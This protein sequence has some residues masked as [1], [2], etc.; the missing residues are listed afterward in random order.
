[1][2]VWVSTK[3]RPE[4]AG[5]GPALECE[6]VRVRRACMRSCECGCVVRASCVVR[7]A[8]I[9]HRSDKVPFVADLVFPLDAVASGMRA[10]AC[11][12]HTGMRSLGLTPARTRRCGRRAGVRGDRHRCDGHVPI[13]RRARRPER[14]R[15]RDQ[16]IP[17]VPWA[18]GRG[19]GR[20]STVEGTR[21]FN[22]IVTLTGKLKGA[23]LGLAIISGRWKLPEPHG[24]F[25]GYWSMWRLTGTA[26]ADDEASRPRVMRSVRSTSLNPEA[27]PATSAPGLG[28]LSP[29]PV[30]TGTGLGSAQCE[31]T[32][33]APVQRLA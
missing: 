24:Q 30:G 28:S 17:C 1:M 19:G 25:Q 2:P 10:H 20:K 4:K 21:A 8:W 14:G 15:E 31:P 16:N 27:T 7:R 18:I 13:R 29:T 26:G 9:P 6:C 11:G 5:N 33:I 12:M 3:A 23:N 32:A 22:G